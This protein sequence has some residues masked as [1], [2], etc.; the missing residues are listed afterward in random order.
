MKLN[1]EKLRAVLFDWDGT[2]AES[3]PPKISAVN[4][5]LNKYGLPDWEKV[6]DLRDNNL[7]FMDNFPKIF[8]KNAREA[9]AEYCEI[10]LQTIKKGLNGYNKAADVIKFLRSRGVKTAIM[11]N[12]DRKLLEAELPLLYPENYFDRIVCGHEALHDK[13]YG[14]HALYTLKGLIDI[15]DI[16]PQTVWIIGDS[17]LDNRCAAAVNALPIRINHEPS[18]SEFCECNNMLYFSDYNALYEALI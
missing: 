8:G 15:K 18:S 10:Y 5:V 2:L 7:S 11:T 14:D 9:Y 6:K 1:C 13:P 4:Q 17:Q 3:N 16:S 12:K